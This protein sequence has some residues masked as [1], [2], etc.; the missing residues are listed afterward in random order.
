MQGGEQVTA[1]GEKMI[2][3]GGKRKV[4]VEKVPGGEKGDNE[5]GKDDIEMGKGE[6]ESG[7][8][9]GRGKGDCERGKSDGVRGKAAGMSEKVYIRG[10]WFR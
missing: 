9:A 5:S 6:G 8:G 10:E 2:M 1:S 7:K 3:K 4:K